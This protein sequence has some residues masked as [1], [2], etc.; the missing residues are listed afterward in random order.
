MDFDGLKASG[1]CASFI[2]VVGDEISASCYLSLIGIIFFR[3][4]GAHSASIGDSATSG[5]LM[6]VDEENGVRA[7]YIAGWK[8]LS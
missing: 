1:V 2:R 3:L 8:P 5:D 6:S 7:F 4:V